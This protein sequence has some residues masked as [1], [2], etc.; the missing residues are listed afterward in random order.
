MSQLGAEGEIGKCPGTFADFIAGF[1]EI[2][3]GKK[4]F[5]G[6]GLHCFMISAFWS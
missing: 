4:A 6:F 5:T 1:S 2:M 3:R